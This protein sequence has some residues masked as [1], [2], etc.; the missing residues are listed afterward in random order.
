M[1]IPAPRCGGRVSHGGTDAILETSAYY[2]LTYG[3]LDGKTRIMTSNGELT[4]PL[5]KYPAKP[6]ASSSF[7]YQRKF[8]VWLFASACQAA[9]QRRDTT[10]LIRFS[11]ALAYARTAKLRWGK[12]GSTSTKA[13]SILAEQY[14]FAAAPPPYRADPFFTDFTETNHV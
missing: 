1:K 9:R 8:D 3:M 13:D 2:R 10:G 7:R 6:T 4:E 11:Q 14:L 12:P 5:P